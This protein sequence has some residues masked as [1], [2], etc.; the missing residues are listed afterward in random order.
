M[1]LRV[2]LL[3]ISLIVG[4]LHGQDLNNAWQAYMS[5]NSNISML[6]AERAFYTDEQMAT[7]NAVDQLKSGSA[8]Y[9]AWYN[10]YLLSN[11]STRQ[12]VILDSLKAIDTEL[13]VLRNRQASEIEDL[14]Y[15]YEELL[16]NFEKGGVLPDEQGIRNLQFDRWQKVVDRANPILFPDYSGLLNLQWRNPEQRKFILTDVQSLLKVKIMELDSIQT[17]REEEEELALRLASFHEDLGLQMEA[18]QDA[19]QRDA[20]GN[21]ENLRGWS[22]VNAASEFSDDRGVLDMATE[23]TTETI[24]LV[25][26][27]VP[28]GDASEMS[29]GQ[30]SGKD[31]NYLKKKLSEYE[32]LLEEINEELD[33]S[34]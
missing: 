25:S 8:W 11:L 18:D 30:R 17:V 34:P 29:L 2:G 10:K 27:N 5:T 19:Q 3:L 24:D 14:K 15:A 23:K 31:L 20:S 6:E 9:N 13:D 32:A 16:E 22:T 4:P 26:V 28:R 7:K 12:L 21:S 33:Q 1:S